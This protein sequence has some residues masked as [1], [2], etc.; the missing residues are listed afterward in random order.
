MLTT[1]MNRAEGFAALISS[2]ACYPTDHLEISCKRLCMRHREPG[3]SY[4][5]AFVDHE[6]SA[7]AITIAFNQQIQ[8]GYHVFQGPYLHVK[9]SSTLT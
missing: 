1:C 7:A 8:K 9:L 5:M 6:L 4:C 3:L 2:Y